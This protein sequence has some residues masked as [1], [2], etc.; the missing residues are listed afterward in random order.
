[1]WGIDK[2]KIKLPY[3]HEKISAPFYQLVYQNKNHVIFY[4]D[5]ITANDLY[6]QNGCNYNYKISLKT[7]Q[8]NKEEWHLFKDICC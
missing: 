5:M 8:N 7:Q 4:H 3:L 6:T 1:M 2:K